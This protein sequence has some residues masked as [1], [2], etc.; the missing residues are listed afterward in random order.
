MP[1]AQAG[2]LNRG[3]RAARA[4]GTKQAHLP[5]VESMTTVVVHSGVVVTTCKPRR[6]TKCLNVKP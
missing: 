3:V 1:G 6:L 4:G 2:T 5:V